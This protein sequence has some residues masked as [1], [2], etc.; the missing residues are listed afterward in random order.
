MNN[1]VSNILVS[2]IVPIYNVEKYLKRCIDSILNQTYK[3]IEIILV[4]D[5][6]KDGSLNICNEYL[7]KDSR[8]KLINQKNKGPSGAKNSGLN[9]IKGKYIV[10]VDSDDYISKDY[11]KKL[12]TSAIKFNADIVECNYFRVDENNEFLEKTDIGFYDCSEQTKIL[13]SFLENINFKNVVWNKIYKKE[14]IG[15]IKF[16]EK[17]KTSEDF[18]FLS[19][20]YL[21]KQKKV[22]IQDYLYYYVNR[23]DSICNLKVSENTLDVIYSREN[24]FDKYNK[25]GLFDLANY[26]ALKII[27]WVYCLYPKYKDKKIKL[28]L[29]KIFKKYYKFAIKS[30]VRSGG[31]K[32]T[33][34][35]K[36]LRYIQYTLFLFCPSL[37]CVIMNVYN[38]KRGK[39]DEIKK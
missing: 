10:F 9:L 35:H 32:L 25:L 27:Y 7:S 2:V 13:K 8:I 3:N 1:E 24:I 29:K 4:N 17:Y 20:I 14:I 31:L 33:K 11:I 6:S 39:S 5:G 37:S 18:E 34:K 12:L 36:F 21:K 15:N 26:I 28:K 23:S 30:N 38:K 16:T 19:N 22:N